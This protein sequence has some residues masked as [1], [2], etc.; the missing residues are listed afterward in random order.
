MVRSGK[1]GAVS[2]IDYWG[3]ELVRRIHYRGMV[4]RQ[5][6]HEYVKVMTQF[7]MHELASLVCRSFTFSSTFRT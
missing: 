5:W 2:E 7:D 1:Y 3:H 6:M 4:I